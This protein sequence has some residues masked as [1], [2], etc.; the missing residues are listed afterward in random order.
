MGGGRLMATL[1]AVVEEWM[2]LPSKKRS[3]KLARE[4]AKSVV[5]KVVGLDG[6][7]YLKSMGEANFLYKML[8]KKKDNFNNLKYES[9]VWKYQAKPRK[10]HPDF[11]IKID[12]TYHWIEYKGE[13]AGPIR[14]KLKDIKRCNPEKSLILVFERG[15]NKL[16]AKSKMTYMEWAKLCGFP[17]FDTQDSAWVNQLLYYL[18]LNSKLNKGG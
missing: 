5:L 7:K 15:L 18:K 11:R 2:Y 6:V 9:D 14:T 13:M 3:R 17:A 4:M 8:K 16:S 12:Q 1:K 10:Y